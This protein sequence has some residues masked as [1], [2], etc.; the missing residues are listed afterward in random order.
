MKWSNKGHELD[1]YGKELVNNYQIRGAKIY[2]FG[3]GLIGEEIRP[4][5]ERYGCFSGY[6]DNDKKKQKSGI[7]KVKVISPEE[8]LSDKKD[9][10]IVI[11]AD[12]KNI[13][14]IKKQLERAGLKERKEFYI[15]TEFMGIT[16]PILSLYFYSQLYVELAQICLTERCSLKCKACAH[17]CYAV[18]V[19]CQDMSIEMAKESADFLFENID[20][21]KEFVLIGGEPFLYNQLEEIIN[22][23]GGKY[24][25]KIITFSIT[26]NGTIVPKKNVMDACRK[27]NVL[28]RISNYSSTLQYLE[29]RYECLI[30]KMIDN[31][32]SYFM[33]TSDYQWMDYGFETVDRKW[34]MGEL[35]KTFNECKT[36]CREIRG[37]KYYYCVMA[38]SVSD[39]LKFGVGK[40]DYLDL[41]QQIN[42]K[43]FL[44]FQLGYS[45]KGYLDMCNY[46]NGKDA[47]NHPIPVA[48]QLRSC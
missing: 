13:P 47:V 4:V 29:N 9:G 38:R 1:E 25:D 20:I 18:N 26:T 7:N 37:S 45:D 10:I 24:R 8:Y 19:N 48:E 39:N 41:Q 44:E 16:F 2:I 34:N 6:I 21:I 3:A 5:F 43:I 31:K 15:C 27:F 40:E 22:Y 46:C 32:I 12:K 14:S 28:I 23:I 33:G 11:A 30:E 36:P 17:G 42:K 35:I